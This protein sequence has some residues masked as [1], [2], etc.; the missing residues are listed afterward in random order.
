MRIIKP[1]S[2]TKYHGGKLTIK[3][4]TGHD[5]FVEILASTSVIC[6]KEVMACVSKISM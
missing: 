2:P 3:Q 6:R 5:Y 1:K 4:Q